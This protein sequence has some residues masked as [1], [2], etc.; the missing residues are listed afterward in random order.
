MKP[1][2]VN[3]VIPR[4]ATFRKGF[5]WVDKTT[6]TPRDLTGCSF[7]MQ[8]RAAKSYPPQPVITEFSSING[9]IVSADLLNGRWE[10]SLQDEDTL[11]LNFP[12]AVYDIDVIFPSGEIKTPVEGLLEPRLKV[13]LP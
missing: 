12:T 8:V 4:G 11:L 13:T 1:A 6:N 2:T 7:R 10:I 3:L 5:Q 9:K